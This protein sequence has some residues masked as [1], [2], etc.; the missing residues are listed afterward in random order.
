M[1]SLHPRL[2]SKRL[3]A[4][5]GLA[6][7]QIAALPAGA[8]AIRLTWTNRVPTQY[9]E[10]WFSNG[11][12]ITFVN[13]GVATVD[14]SGLA[15]NTTYSF[16]VTHAVAGG[17]QRSLPSNVA[18]ATTQIAFNPPT[19]VSAVQRGDLPAGTSTI[20]VTWANAQAA[21]PI[22][23]FRDG[24]YVGL[25]AAGTTLWDDT[26]LAPSSGHSYF[27][28]HYRTTASG[29]YDTA[30]S[31]G[32]SA[33]T[34]EKFDAP[35]G[36]T[37]SNVLAYP[38]GTSQ[39]ALNWVNAQAGDQIA[40]YRYQ[41]SWNYLTTVAAGT[42]SYT[43]SGLAP[44][45][46]YYY[47]LI[48]VRG[49]YSTNA[50]Q[51][52]PVSTH[53]LMPSPVNAFVSN[54]G[55]STI[56]LNWTNGSGTDTVRVYISVG[57]G[58]Y[59]PYDYGAGT[60]GLAF[61]GLSAGTSYSFAVRHIRYGTESTDPPGSSNW[62]GAT[63]QFP[64][65]AAPYNLQVGVP[66][67]QALIVYW[68]NG[69]G[70]AQTEVYLNGGGV[71]T[72]GPGVTQYQI[73][74][75]TRCTNYTIQL[76]ALKNGVY[77]G[78]VSIVGRPRMYVS[79]G[80]TQNDGATEYHW[81]Y[82]GDFNITLQVPGMINYSGFGRGGYGG[83][84]NPTEGVDTGGGGGGAGGAFLQ[85]DNIEPAGTYYVSIA[86]TYGPGAT[87]Y[88]DD[89]AFNG[90]GGE[91]GQVDRGG[92]GGQS[93][94]GAGSA[95]PAYGGGAPLFGGPGNSS[96][97]GGGGGAAGPGGAASTQGGGGG[98]GLGLP[99]FGAVCVG[100]NGGRGANAGQNASYWGGGGGGGNP[101]GAGG[102]MDGGFLVWFPI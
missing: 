90:Y 55:T 81:Y 23:V 58:G 89:I 35:S 61:T 79:G 57:G 77:S 16:Y 88:R 75:L 28:R 56:N 64:A 32:T 4:P 9:T 63:T 13:P 53:A 95:Y 14:I 100:G 39:L 38:A 51:A 94:G 29:S 8:T 68:A 33:T 36:L 85:Y 83:G 52:G 27:L 71:T 67:D 17:L 2:Y 92:Y 72:V 91:L 6:A 26:G 82:Q 69:D 73:N 30:N 86:W 101:R 31:N 15:S 3:S 80:Y 49:A 59:T 99:I 46:Y 74:G 48:H 87:A 24:A 96:G 5:S 50:H 11:T 22:E 44:G 10:I 41:T 19:N 21:D 66:H 20:R 65:P 47:Y 76:R 34:Q 42:T 25:L 54:V 98:A 102:P 12:A 1:E 97:G 43:D 78:F 70:G 62:A 37:I 7:A 84:G 40:I 45:T 18:S 60:A 93:G